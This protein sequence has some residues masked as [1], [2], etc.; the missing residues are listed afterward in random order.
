MA[1]QPGIPWL[2]TDG[3]VIGPIPAQLMSDGYNDTITFTKPHE[4]IAITS[5]LPVSRESVCRSELMDDTHLTVYAVSTQPATEP[6]TRVISGAQSPFNDLTA[7]EPYAG[8]NTQIQQI[9][10]DADALHNEVER[11][12]SKRFCWST[13]T[14]SQRT[15]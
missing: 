13:R 11:Q 4:V 10:S 14:L 1:H 12:D 9:L 2:W 3:T 7:E 6:P 15:L 8:F 5:I